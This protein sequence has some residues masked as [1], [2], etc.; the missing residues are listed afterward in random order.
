[1]ISLFTCDSIRCLFVIVSMVEVICC[2]LRY[3]WVWFERMFLESIRFVPLR[4]FLKRCEV[5]G[6]TFNSKTADLVCDLLKALVI[7]ECS[8]ASFI[9]KSCRISHFWSTFE[10]FP[11]CIWCSL[12][13]LWWNMGRIL[14]NKTKKGLLVRFKVK[15]KVKYVVNALVRLRLW[16]S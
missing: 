11:F 16:A 7:N 13:A 6:Y 4:V 8:C 14:R 9:R 1:M 2:P 3:L 12:K 10:S 5:V 15:V